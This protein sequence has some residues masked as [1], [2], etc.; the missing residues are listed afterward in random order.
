M[1][2]IIPAFVLCCGCALPPAQ[3]AE[4]Q[5][6]VNGGPAEPQAA[7]SA[8]AA[9]QAAPTETM[10]EKLSRVDDLLEP[11]ESL[12]GLYFQEHG[13]FPAQA[14]AWAEIGLSTPAHWPAGIASMSIA[15]GSGE[16]TVVLS[17][18]GSG[19]DGT[20]VKSAPAASPQG[21]GLKWTRTCTSKA[22]VVKHYLGC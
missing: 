1:K 16:V 4:R 21:T 8:G 20:T 18:L 2:K 19:N 10:Q 14:D 15:A 12:L 22:A 3:A 17:G 9:S 7:A 11:V 6:I 13:K 5:N